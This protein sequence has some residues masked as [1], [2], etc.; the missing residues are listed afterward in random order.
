MRSPFGGFTQHPSPRMQEYIDSFG[1]IHPCYTDDIALR[2]RRIRTSFWCRLEP[3]GID[4]TRNMHNLLCAESV[5]G[6][7]GVA[8]R[9]ENPVECVRFAQKVQHRLTQWQ[10]GKMTDIT[11]A[12]RPVS[13]TDFQER[14]FG[15]SVGHQRRSPF[16]EL[17]TLCLAWPRTLDAQNDRLMREL[18]GECS[19]R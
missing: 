7:I 10:L 15:Q 16:I 6:E 17:Y 2:S 1:I 11:R 5:R 3:L 18:T 14:L 19:R 9:A 12:C 13:Q 8:A 4:T